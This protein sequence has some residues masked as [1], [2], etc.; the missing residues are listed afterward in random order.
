[1]KFDTFNNRFYE[2][3][4]PQFLTIKTI[5]G[6]N[7]YTHKCCTYP[8]DQTT[9]YRFEKNHSEQKLRTLY[10]DRIFKFTFARMETLGE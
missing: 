9:F 2:L 8:Q 7:Y 1:M 4:Y 5:Q 6:P 10:W 3:D